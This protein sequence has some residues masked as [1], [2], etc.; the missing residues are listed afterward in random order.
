MCRVLILM[1]GESVLHTFSQ[2]LD[3]SVWPQSSGKFSLLNTQAEGA[4]S[5]FSCSD[6]R[7][8]ALC[9]RSRLPV[10]LDTWEPRFLWH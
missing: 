3:A 7:L 10:I 9:L 1:E 5:V 8:F 2:I 4:Q 6:F